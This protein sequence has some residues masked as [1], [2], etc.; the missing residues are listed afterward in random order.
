MGIKRMGS[1]DLDRNV[2]STFAQTHLNNLPRCFPLRGRKQLSLQSRISPSLTKCCQ[3]KKRWMVFHALFLSSALFSDKLKQ[4]EDNDCS[5]SKVISQWIKNWKGFGSAKSGFY[6]AVVSIRHTG[7]PRLDLQKQ[8]EKEMYF[9]L[10]S[11]KVSFT[12]RGA[13]M[14]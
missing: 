3:K 12:N 8:W 4:R 11:V 14:Q 2:H 1:P 5:R 6:K 10:A 7:G 9:L 13:E